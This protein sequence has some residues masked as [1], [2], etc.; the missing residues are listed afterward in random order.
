[1][2]R[3]K[4]IALGLLI[5]GATNFASAQVGKGNIIIDPYYGYPNIGKQ[6]AEGVNDATGEV[7]VG[8]IGPA[9]LRFEYMLADNFGLGFDFIYNSANLNF[10]VDSLNNDGTVFRSYD[11]KTSMQRVRFHLRANYHFVQD[12]SFDAYVGFGAGTNNRFWGLKTDHP[13]YEDDNAGGTLIPV[14]AR[15]CLGARY[16]F[17]DNFGLSTELGLGGPLISAGLSLKF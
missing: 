6:L 16:Y 5:I 10:M 1:M 11:V 15:I 4:S 9:G 14:S 3:L 17:T 7:T 2:K 12:D 13:S 8:G